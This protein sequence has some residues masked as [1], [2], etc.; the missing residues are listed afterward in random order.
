[1]KHKREYKPLYCYFDCDP[2]VYR[3]AFASQKTKYFFEKDG[4]LVSDVFNSADGA[5]KWLQQ[6]EEFG[7]DTSEYKRESIIEYLTPKQARRKFD[8]IIKEYK[9]A[10][11]DT[12]ISFLGLLTP[13]G[14]KHKC[15]KGIEHQYQG[16]RSSLP[17]KPKYFEMLRE[18]A[19]GHPFI[20]VCD[21]GYEADEFLI[22]YAERDGEDAV[23]VSIDKDMCTAQNTWVIHMAK[24]GSGT[25]VWNTGLGHLSLETRDSGKIGVGGGFKYLAYQAISGDAVDGYKGCLGVGHVKAVETII[26][27]KTEAEVVESCLNL[28]KNVYGESY[29]YTSWDGVTYDKTPYQMLQMHFELPYMGAKTGKPFNLGDYYEE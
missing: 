21:D 29:Q 13:V 16:N 18:Y 14:D 15:I 5:K 9:K 8:K 12:I 17:E 10:A 27:C 26:D 11:G 28:Y 19:E 3:A 25:P 7:I 23:V 2:I 24:D 4:V 20:K 22:H 1:M 6:M